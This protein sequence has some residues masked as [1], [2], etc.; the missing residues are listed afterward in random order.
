MK[1]M[2]QVFV[3]VVERGNFSRAAEH[4][5]MTQPAV[6][7]YV[8]MLEEDVGATLLER[9]NRTVHMT[10]A[11]EIVYQH[12]KQIIGHVETMHELVHDLF[13]E[14]SGELAIGASYT[15]GEYILPHIISKMREQYPAIHP[16]ITIGN[17]KEI[18][19][20]VHTMDLDIGIV[21]GEVH[22]RDLEVETIAEDCMVIVVGCHHPLAH[23]SSVTTEDLWNTTWI[24]R[25]EGSGT[26][27]TTER[28]FQTLQIHPPQTMEFG[29]TQLIKESVE[30]GLGVTLLSQ[31]TIRK[32]LSMGTL[33]RVNVPSGE[34]HRSFSLLLREKPMHTKA[35]E[36]FR[37]LLEKVI[38][39]STY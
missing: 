36:I 16:A 13:H 5:Y 28:L 14:P 33:K 37:E 23:Q 10:K 18:A 31:W 2:L 12:A 19:E 9:A 4:L 20:R 34:I 22:H 24:I 26:R 1:Q 38:P 30:A 32:E 7:Q 8:K 39:P 17:T 15:Y 29:S 11:G 25:E 3:Q 35:T 27:E 6:S 21:E